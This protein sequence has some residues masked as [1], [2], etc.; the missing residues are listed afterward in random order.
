MA[1]LWVVIRGWGRS[2]A[3]H[4]RRA[5]FCTGSS[6]SS[7]GSDCSSSPG[8]VLVIAEGLN[9]GVSVATGV[10]VG[11]L[12]VGLV[13]FI[14]LG[15]GLILVVRSERLAR[16]IGRLVERTVGA[17]LHRLGRTTVPDVEG[18]WSDSG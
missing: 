9:R 17:V 18:A 14:L 6:T 12:V 1:V 7:A 5:S 2:A 4:D 8:V 13:L 11:C 16:K 10:I 15:G 3:G